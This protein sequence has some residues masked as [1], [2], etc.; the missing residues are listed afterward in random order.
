MKELQPNERPLTFDEMSRRI[1]DM[2]MSIR[3][4]ERAKA[5][6]Q[7]AERFAD[8][9]FGIFTALRSVA[10]PFAHWFAQR[11]VRP[12]TRRS[13]LRNSPAPR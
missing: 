4:R 6:L 13:T 11:L 7:S 10:P 12:S 9:L 8:G 3:D 2:P 1:D 5:S